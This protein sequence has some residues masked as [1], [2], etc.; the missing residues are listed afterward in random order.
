LDI[1][2]L[3]QPVM[4]LPQRRQNTNWDSDVKPFPKK[5]S[6]FGLQMEWRGGTRWSRYGGDSR[7]NAQE[8]VYIWKVKLTDIFNKKHTYVGHVNIVR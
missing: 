3:G 2:P 1:R 8:D 5:K 4:G 6:F 7:K